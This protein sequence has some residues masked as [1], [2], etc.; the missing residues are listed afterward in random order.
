MK[1]FSGLMSIFLMGT[2]FIATPLRGADAAEFE[3]LPTFQAAEVLGTKALQGENFVIEPLATNDGT[4]NRFTVSSPD[5]T[6]KV[7][8]NEHALERARE[9][10]AIAVI[11]RSKTSTAYADG[12]AAAISGPLADAKEAITNPLRTLENVPGAVERLVG[13]LVSAVAN[14]GKDD[15]SGEENGLLKDLIG[16][17]KTKRNLAHDLGVDAYSTNPVL[18]EELSDLAWAS[19]AGGATIDL[20]LAVATVGAGTAIGALDRVTLSG[21]LLREQSASTLANISKQHLEAMWLVE[22]EVD[23]FLANPHYPVSLQTRLVQALAVIEGVRGRGDFVVLANTAANEDTARFY[24][25]TAEIIGAYHQQLNPVMEVVLRGKTVSFVTKDG[26]TVT[27][28]PAD[29]L[30]WTPDTAE[31]LTGLLSATG[32]RSLWVIGWISPITRKQLTAAGVGVQENLFSRLVDRI[33]IIPT[34]TKSSKE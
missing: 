20:G 31:R 8:G 10:T 16:Y 12:L 15:G 11:R 26:R 27:P 5:L 33:E 6:S 21:D 2:I 9:M 30:T 1:T 7:L 4:M 32:E 19:F 23:S 24:Q 13:D 28:L 14:I 18:Q 29:Y 34:E 22:K 17:S 3:K 25:R